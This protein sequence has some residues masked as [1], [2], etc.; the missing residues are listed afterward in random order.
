MILSTKDYYTQFNKISEYTKQLKNTIRINKSNFKHFKTIFKHFKTIFK[1]FK[2]YFKDFKTYFKDF[3]TI[4]KDFKTNFKDFKTNFKD[5]KTIFKDFKT[6]FKYL[7]IIFKDFKTNFKHF[8]AYKYYFK[9]RKCNH[10][11]LNCKIITNNREIQ[12]IFSQLNKYFSSNL[13]E[14]TYCVETLHATSLQVTLIKTPHTE[15]N[16]WEGFL[17]V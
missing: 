12:E 17:I 4:F 5:F 10:N 7:E 1:H 9:E 15:I 16:P 6:I 11:H 2:T 3:K 14:I 13:G 8:I